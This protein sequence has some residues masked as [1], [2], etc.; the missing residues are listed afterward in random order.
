MTKTKR[1]RGGRPP[2]PIDQ[3]LGFRLNIYL[4]NAMGD[5]LEAL[6]KKQGQTISDVVRGVLAKHLV[7]RR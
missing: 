5:E 3:K 7:E 6:A 4:R 1:N 2:L